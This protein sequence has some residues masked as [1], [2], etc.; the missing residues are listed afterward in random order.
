M[1]RNRQGKG[2]ALATIIKRLG[3]ILLALIAASAPTAAADRELGEYLSS[4]CTTCH[5]LS[6][7]SN[8]I[9]P[10]VGWDTAS[11]IAVMQSYKKRERDNKAMQNIA[12]TFS[13]EDIA[14]LAAYFATIKPK[15]E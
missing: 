9:P 7:K 8:G 5:Q 13:D 3:F 12:G 11:F 14:A 4:Q 15:D 10:I 6:G 1:G 2:S